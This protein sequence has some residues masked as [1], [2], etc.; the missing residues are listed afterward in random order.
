MKG[1]RITKR[2]ERYISYRVNKISSN[3][4]KITI[5]YF[6]DDGNPIRNVDLQRVK[7]ITCSESDLRIKEKEIVGIISETR[8]RLIRAL[9]ALGS[10]EA[11][12]EA[13]LK[14]KMR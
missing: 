2:S 7:Y 3:E 6:I 13:F 5:N 4:Y 14:Q 1:T 10:T 9:H 11:N 12:V 8:W